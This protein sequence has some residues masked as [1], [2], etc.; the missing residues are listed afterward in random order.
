LS[1]NLLT[2][3]S[4]DHMLILVPSIDWYPH[5]RKSNSWRSTK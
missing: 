4:Q 2:P 3:G 1:N 5:T